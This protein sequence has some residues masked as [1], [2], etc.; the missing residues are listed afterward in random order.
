MGEYHVEVVGCV[1]DGAS[2]GARLFSTP[3]EEGGEPTSGWLVE[4]LLRR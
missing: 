1:L 2:D 4:N 3:E